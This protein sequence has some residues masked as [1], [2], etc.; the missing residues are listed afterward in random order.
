MNRFF[1]SMS[2]LGILLVAL[3]VVNLVSSQ[4]YHKADITEEKLYSLSQGTKTIL[5]KLESELH[6]KYYV[7]KDSESVPL[8]LKSYGQRIAELFQEYKDHS[9]GKI[10]LEVLDPKADT[11]DEEWAGKYGIKGLPLPSGD[12]FRMGAVFLSGSGEEVIEFFNPQK[13]TFLEYE[14][15]EAI[16]KTQKSNRKK[17]AVLSSYDMFPSQFQFQM[18][19]QP[20]PKKGWMIIKELQKLYDLS[21]LKADAKTIPD[22]DLLMIIHP[23]Q[24]SDD[25]TYAI[26]QYVMNGGSMVVMVDPSSQSEQSQQQ[27][28]RPQGPKSSDLRKLFVKWGIQYNVNLVTGDVDNSTRIRSAQGVVDFPIW[29]TLKEPNTNKDNIAVSNLETLMMIEAGSLS[30]ND[31]VKDVT[32]DSLI[33]TSVNAGQIQSRQINRQDPMS[34][35]K[36]LNAVSKKLSVAGIYSG[37]FQSAFSE[38]PKDHP[39]PMEHKTSSSNGS[40]FVIADTDFLADQYAVQVMNFLGQSILQKLNDNFSLVSNTVEFM[41]GDKDLISIRSRGKFSRPFDRVVNMQKAAQARYKKQEE[42]QTKRLQEV[43]AKINQRQNVKKEGNKLV[44]SRS[45]IEEI[46]RFRDE[47]RQI[48]KKRREIRKNL[49]EDV[50]KLGQ[51]LTF[52]NVFLIP[53]LVGIYGAMRVLNYSKGGR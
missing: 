8:Y 34:I 40:I 33:D 22:V 10:T 44:L 30:L 4:F 45:A 1:D 46:E 23:K 19:N 37:K 21:E 3:I 17:I 41:C 31:K 35:S 5:G 36:N 52:S 49:R 39:L 26:D 7:N 20:P 14:I 47:E 32:F 15:T 16:S 9:K 42:E 50:E 29:M 24:I 51:K 38:K 48:K 13:E 6:I 53:F 43:Q 2:S 28:G 27:M 25:M 11:E 12:S 18:P